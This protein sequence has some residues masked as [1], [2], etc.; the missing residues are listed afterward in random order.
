MK[1]RIS[2]GTHL[3]APSLSKACPRSGP[4]GQTAF[5]DGLS[6]CPTMTSLVRGSTPLR[7]TA[8]LATSGLALLLLAFVP[9]GVT[10]AQDASPTPSPAVASEDGSPLPEGFN[11]KMVQKVAEVID[12]VHPIRGLPPADGVDYRVIDEEMFQAELGQLFL[13]EYGEAYVKAEDD[14][15][16]RLGLI[17]AD[18]DLEELIFALYDSQV[19]AYYDPRTTTFSLIGPSRKI[20]ALESIVVAHEYGH[21][22][23]DAQWDLEGSRIK[24]LDRSDAI[25]A[26]QALIEGD[27]TAVMYDWAAREL[28]LV[29]LLAVSASALTNQD[30]RKLQRVPAILRR[31][32]EFPYIDGFAFV[33]AIR[34][35][36]DWGAVNDA[37]EAAPVSTEQILHPEL[38]PDEAPVEIRLPDVAALL[39]PGWSTSYEQTF[40]EMQIGVWVADGGKARALFPV[41]PAQ[42]PRAEVAA[43]WGGD[44]LLSLDGPEGA[45]A[46]V[47]QTDW[48]SSADAKEFREAARDAMDDLPGAHAVAGAD[49]S[50]G[51]S[52]PVLV[53]VAESEGTLGAVQS[54]LDLD[55]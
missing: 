20:G 40:G 29:D 22:L 5:C 35:R 2:A 47:W 41:L 14:A 45:W 16:T 30:A 50:G 13:E 10:H 27:A 4:A 44:R 51:L 9:A 55:I 23:Q 34:G 15:F 28:D 49:I 8:R 7:R 42:L 19:L 12:E 52:S 32:L 46:L 6:E 18:D 1:K 36:G 24:E 26:Q 53:L 11:Q 39:G 54:A 31:Q 21:A 25:L 3:G 38:Y 37:W 43:G 48:D 17:D 33:N